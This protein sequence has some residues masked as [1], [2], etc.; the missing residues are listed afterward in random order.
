MEA[1]N[2]KTSGTSAADHKHRAREQWGENPCGAHIAKHLEPGTRAYYDAIER[3]RYDVYAPWM[4]ETIGFER[5]GGK[6]VLEVGCGTGTDLLQ[7]ARAGALVTGVDLTPQSIAITRDKFRAYGFDGEFAVADAESLNFPDGKFDVVY[8]FGVLHH[9]PDTGGA[10]AEMHRVLKPG[11]EAV[12]MLYNRSSLFYWL[13]IILKRGIM[14]GQLLTRSPSEIMSRC[15]EYTETG[16]RPL[17]KAYTRS[18]AL[19]LFSGFARCT[20]EVRQ[21]TREELRLIGRLVPEWA[22]QRLARRFGWNLVI[23]AVKTETTDGEGDGVL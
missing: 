4:K 7:F 8:S 10:I 6:R 17:V 13:S 20:I 15:V 16:G 19:R 1:V 21:L 9:T 14:R 2:A 23:R 5:Y 12:V 3:F 18:E 22:F 11:G